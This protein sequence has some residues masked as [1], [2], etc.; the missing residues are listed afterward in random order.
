M[1]HFRGFLGTSELDLSVVPEE[2]QGKYGAGG[3]DKMVGMDSF[4]RESFREATP[5]VDSMTKSSQ[6]ALEVGE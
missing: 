2:Y 5:L 1:I 6:D 4:K 3:V